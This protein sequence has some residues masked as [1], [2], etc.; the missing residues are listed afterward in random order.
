[1]LEGSDA[2]WGWALVGV[3]VGDVSSNATAI[4]TG[5]V[6]VDV[7]GCGP[8]GCTLRGEG[9]ECAA[10]EAVTILVSSSSGIDSSSCDVGGFSWF[11]LKLSYASLSS[12]T[13]GSMF[14]T[15]ASWVFMSSSCF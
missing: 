6:A 12:F 3:T 11:S 9:G 13:T 8:D 2:S 4:G 14:V 5:G 10:G 1:M 15:I 7:D